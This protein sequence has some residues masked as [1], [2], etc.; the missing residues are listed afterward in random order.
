[1][2]GRTENSIKNHWNTTKRS[3]KPKLKENRSRNGSKGK[4]LENYI[5]EVT[6]AQKCEKEMMDNGNENDN[7]DFNYG[8]VPTQEDDAGG[9]VDGN[10]MKD[11]YGIIDY[12]IGI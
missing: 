10:E 8:D 7:N 3:L 1:L 12:E 2:P 4:L 6:I 5:R 9:Y 11:G